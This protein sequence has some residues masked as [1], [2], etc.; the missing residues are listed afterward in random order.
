MLTMFLKRVRARELVLERGSRKL[1]KYLEEAGVFDGPA[2]E[3]YAP[4]WF[5]HLKIARQQVED[6]FFDMIQKVQ[7][8][9]VRSIES[10]GQ[11]MMFHMKN[12]N[13]RR[14]TQ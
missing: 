12:R 3:Y 13:Q 10:P 1:V 11:F 14:V 6:C 4:F 5:K 7:E 2:G 9:G 8:Q